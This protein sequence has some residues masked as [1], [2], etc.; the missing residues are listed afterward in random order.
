MFPRGLPGLALLLLRAST[1]I[2]VVIECYAHRS[3]LPGWIQT[4]AWVVS[5]ALCAGFL[6]PIL[7]LTGLAFH[8]F[9]W[10]GLDGVPW[11]FMVIRFLDV[12]ALALLGPG[13]YSVDAYRF[14]QRLVVL[15]P[16]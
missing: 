5:I 12:V 11:A 14:G 13:A 3:E 16:P 1:A 10:L 15:P 7:A 6:T 4:V 2:A 8:G 9:V